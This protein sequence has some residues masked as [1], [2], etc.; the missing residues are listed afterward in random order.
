MRWFRLSTRSRPSQPAGARRPPNNLFCRRES[1]GFCSGQISAVIAGLT[2]G[3]QPRNVLRSTRI[4]DAN[5]R[6]KVRR[7]RLD[8][9]RT[10]AG[11]GKRID[12]CAWDA[13][14]RVGNQ[15][16]RTSPP[17]GRN[18]LEP[19]KIAANAQADAGQSVGQG[20]LLG[21]MAPLYIGY[22]IPITAGDTRDDQIET[23]NLL[24]F[25]S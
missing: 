17:F 18:D 10:A 3:G 19:H 24:A 23:A 6:D 12:E 11:G 13:A 22:V 4:A 15:L 2:A 20:L 9:H 7:F 14:G 5:S 16:V 1:A 25:N 21:R 8:Q